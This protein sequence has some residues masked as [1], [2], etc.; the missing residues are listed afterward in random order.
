[1]IMK[2]QGPADELV[3][4]SKDKLWAINKIILSDIRNHTKIAVTRA[5]AE[6]IDTKTKAI[7]STININAL[8]DQISGAKTYLSEVNQVFNGIKERLKE[9]LKKHRNTISGLMDKVVGGDDAKYVKN[10]LA[11][12]DN[13]LIEV[14]ALSLVKQTF[15]EY[16][17]PGKTQAERPEVLDLNAKGYEI[18]MMVNNVRNMTEIA[19]NKANTEIKML[20]TDAKL[21]LT[22]VKS[23][24]AQ[25]MNFK[26][27]QRVLKDLFLGII[28]DLQLTNW[29][30]MADDMELNIMMW[31]VS[32][33]FTII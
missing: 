22:R 14:N 17:D 26:S 8:Y 9:E 23:M 27:Y 19:I 25:I 10:E 11:K 31:G 12:L 5:K 15:C 1:M 33:D 32:N 24:D 21:A 13:K 4:P 2:V 29:L 30:L 3:T 20:R 18:K 6:M 16:F 28:Y 7:H